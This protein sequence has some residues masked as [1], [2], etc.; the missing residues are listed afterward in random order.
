MN[1]PAPRADIHVP[2]YPLL[3]AL[4]AATLVVLVLACG[5]A[6]AA[7]AGPTSSTGGSGF[8]VQPVTA[9]KGAFVGKP[10]ELNGHLAGATGTISITAKRGKA[11]WLPIGTAEADAYGDFT[12]TWTPPKHGRYNF[13]FAEPGATAAS[14]D[15][16]PQGTV[17]VYRRQKATWYGPGFYGS[18]TACGQKLTRRTLGVAHKTLPCGTRVE[19]F[20]RGK[21]ITLPV[22]DRGPY[23]NGATWDLTLTAMKRL[24]SS[25]TEVLG[26][27]AL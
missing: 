17:S 14:D 1:L 13:R 2:R 5:S 27:L 7:D 15:A 16:P 20:L 3:A 8:I 18:R 19:F 26:A 22:I 4:I 12:F 25:S 21:R 11:D 6:S 10:A 24:G 9:P 23:A